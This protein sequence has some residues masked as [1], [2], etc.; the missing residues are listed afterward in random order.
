MRAY[1]FKE[2]P[3]EEDLQNMSDTIFLPEGALIHTEQNLKN[4][5]VGNGLPRALAP[6]WKTN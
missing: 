1:T 6:Q 4:I 5:S 2:I 3:Y